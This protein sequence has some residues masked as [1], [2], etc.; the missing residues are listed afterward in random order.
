MHGALPLCRSRLVRDHE[1]AI[2]V[3]RERGW[4]VLTAQGH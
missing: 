2:E 3:A 1:R 4:A